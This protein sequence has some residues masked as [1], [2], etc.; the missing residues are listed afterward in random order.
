VLEKIARDL[1]GDEAGEGQILV[2]GADRPI[3]IAPRV[4]E[5][6]AP[7][8]TRGLAETCDVEPMPP[9]ALAETRRCEEP[10]DEARVGFVRGIAHERIDLLGRRRKA[11]EREPQPA[12]ELLRRSV[13]DGP[14]TRLLELREDEAVDR[15]F[16]NVRAP[17]RRWR[18]LRR[19]RRQPTPARARERIG[20][21]G[22]IAIAAAIRSARD[23]LRDALVRRVA[24]ILRAGAD[25]LLERAN[26]GRGKTDARRH[27]KLGVLMPERAQKEARLGV[28]GNDHRAPFAA[29]SN[30]FARI[31]AK[32][33]SHLL[34]TARM[35][36][37]AVLD[38]HRANRLLEEVEAALVGLRG[39]PEK[40]DDED[41]QDSRV[42]V[43]L[44]T[45]PCHLSREPAGR[46]RGRGRSHSRCTRVGPSLNE[47]A[48][49]DHRSSSPTIATRAEKR[50][51]FSRM[52]RASRERARSVSEHR[53]WLRTAPGRPR[54]V[55]ERAVRP[56]AG[57]PDAP[58]RL[59]DDERDRRADLWLVFLIGTWPGA[60]GSR[61][62]RR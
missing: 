22:A 5:E 11:N 24:R 33:A 58:G 43:G 35:A 60:Y 62:P 8:A 9:E 4:L 54:S 38:E 61:S 6:D 19:K 25:P 21:F 52:R 16:K 15:A 30:S 27:A 51:R 7:A 26:R 12:H 34:G 46:S 40:A 28:A 31:E 36:L 53:G 14:H 42:H 47:A 49:V 55:G 3:A 50:T 44:A 18:R 13:T 1:I 45:R 48:E 17:H 2:E 56:S 37:V 10:V 39:G 23:R 29:A 20:S 59:P 32:P 41:R 57:F